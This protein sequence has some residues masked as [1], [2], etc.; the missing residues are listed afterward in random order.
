MAERKNNTKGIRIVG[1]NDVY[2]AILG[3]AFLVL[4]GTTAVVCVYGQQL[5]GSFFALTKQAG[6]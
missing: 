1:F 6:L 3:L 4:A 5:Y 2:T